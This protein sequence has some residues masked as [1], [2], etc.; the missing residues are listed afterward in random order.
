MKRRPARKLKRPR[1]RTRGKGLSQLPVNPVTRD[2]M[3]FHQLS[4]DDAIAKAE[5]AAAA[6]PLSDA[7]QLQ[8][9]RQLFRVYVVMK[10]GHWR[11]LAQLAYETKD[12]EASV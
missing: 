10:D 12:P 9:S 4:L 6:A 2:F 7:A 1:K 5:Q 11:S 3:Q 8:L